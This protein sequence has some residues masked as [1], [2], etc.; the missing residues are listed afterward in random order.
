MPASN[1][2][3]SAC[4]ASRAPWAISCCGWW[5]G[6]P[7]LEVFLL[8]WNIG[9]VRTLFR[10][11]TI[12]TLARWMAHKRIHTR[13][14]SAATLGASH[15]HKIVV[16]DDCVAFCGGIDT[17]SNRW[18]TPEHRDG[19]PRRYRPGRGAPMH[20]G[21]MRPPYL[22]GPIAAALGE[23]GRQRWQAAGAGGWRR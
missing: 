10:G 9:A 14:D 6:N 21:M 11:T 4:P 12:F 8:R 17:T 3:T 13:L 23:L 18:D 2:A 20:P 16:I 7:E 15:H 5:S 22:E 19:D 1:S